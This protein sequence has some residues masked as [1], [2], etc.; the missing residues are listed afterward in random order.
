MTEILLRTRFARAG[1]YACLSLRGL[2][3]CLPGALSRLR[4][5]LGLRPSPFVA[6]AFGARN[7][8]I[9]SAATLHRPQGL[10]RHRF[11]KV[12]ALQGVNIKCAQVFGLL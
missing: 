2:A 3:R 4:F 9:A 8:Y 7:T 5:G 11:M 1:R 12:K 6:C 10:Q